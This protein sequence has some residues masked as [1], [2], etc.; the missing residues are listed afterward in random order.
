MIIIWLNVLNTVTVPIFTA[1]LITIV[2]VN[3][4]III[5]YLFTFVFIFNVLEMPYNFID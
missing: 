5:I 2:F 1:I 3:A 4:I